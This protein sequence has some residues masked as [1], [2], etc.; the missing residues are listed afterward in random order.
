MSR[1]GL[2]VLVGISA[3]QSILGGGLY[4]W[5][6]VAGLSVGG[7]APLEFDASDPA[8]SRVDYMFRAIAGIWLA[9]GLM[10]AY[11]IRTIEKH[12]AWFTLACSGI[13]AMGV[14]RYLSS[15]SFPAAPENSRGAMIAELMIPPIYV[16]WQR[17]VARGFSEQPVNE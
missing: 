12:T 1:R 13:F 3:L 16:L 8:W 9:L 4:L 11:M 5:L 14:G 15:I 2:Q 10:F 7:V 17:R 6:G